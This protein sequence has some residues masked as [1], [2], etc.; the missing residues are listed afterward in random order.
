MISPPT[1]PADNCSLYWEEADWLP[2]W[3]ILDQWCHQDERCRQAKQQA[4]L[5]ACERGEVRFQRSDGKTFD[6]PVHE[7]AARGIL[8]IERESLNAWA[9]KLDG[10]SPL[11]ASSRAVNIPPRPAWADASWSPQDSSIPAQVKPSANSSSVEVAASAAAALAPNQ[12]IPD[13]NTKSSP[14]TDKDTNPDYS[15]YPSETELR[16]R[17]VPANEIIAAFPVEQNPADNIAWWKERMDNTK[18]YKK[19]AVAQVQKGLPNRGDA[20]YPSWWQPDLVTRWL[21][22]A[23]HMPLYQAVPILR[24]EFPFWSKIFDDQ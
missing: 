3:Y 2:P 22:D 24:T 19:L 20:H 1:A 21:L 23:R 12:S 8:L 13:V 4:L 11:S 7:L 18:R 9:I 14:N 10:A 5:S 6:D 17:G 15:A 16:Q